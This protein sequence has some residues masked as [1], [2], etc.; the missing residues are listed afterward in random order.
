MDL[1]SKCI[2]IEDLAERLSFSNLLRVSLFLNMESPIV[3][4]TQRESSPE[5]GIY[6]FVVSKD[7]KIY[8][9]YDKS[10]LT[11]YF[12]KYHSKD[13]RLIFIPKKGVFYIFSSSVYMNRRHIGSLYVVY[14]VA[15]DKRFWKVLKDIP[16]SVSVLWCDFNSS[17]VWDIKNKKGLK[18]KFLLKKDFKLS[19]KN[20]FYAQNLL[21]PLNNKDF[22]YIFVLSSTNNFVQKIRQFTKLIFLSFIFVFMLSFFVAYLLSKR[23]T[24]PVNYLRKRCLFLSKN[25]DSGILEVQR[26]KHLEFK[27]LAEAFNKVLVSFLDAQKKLQDWAKKEISKSER[28][29]QTLVEVSPVGILALG[30]NK[31]PILWNDSFLDILNFSSQD[32]KDQDFFSFFVS[33][34]VPKIKSLFEKNGYK[35]TESV[36]ARVF[37]KDGDTKWVEVYVN[38]IRDEKAGFLVIM[39]DIDERK[40]I[41]E[42]KQV[43]INIVEQVPEA[44]ILTHTDGSIRYANKAFEDLFGCCLKEIKG[45]KIEFLWKD[46]ELFRRIFHFVSKGNSWSGRGEN[47]KKN[48]DFINVYIIVAP[49]KDPLGRIKNYLFVFQD[50]TKEVMLEKEVSKIQKLQAIGTLASGIAHDFNNILTTI[51]GHIQMATLSLSPKDK[52]YSYLEKCLEGCVRA[53]DLISQLLSFS[54]P[55]EEKKEP[56]FLTPIIKEA[57]KF[58]NASLPSNIKINLDIK[59]PSL[60]IVGNVTQVYQILANLITNAAYAMKEKGGN[61]DIILDKVVLDF[62]SWMVEKKMLLPGEYVLL[63]VKDTGVG[64]SPEVLERAFEPF[65]T[66]K[67]KGEGTGMG[68]AVVFGIVKSYN[69]HIYIESKENQGTSVFIYLPLYKKEAKV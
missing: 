31:E 1:A 20:L 35:K 13:P 38:R 30:F 64:M 33:E 69:G 49:L 52:V 12:G 42:E 11:F 2:E 58:F 18:E 61:I 28:R 68:L 17:L 10:F 36:E 26:L 39:V 40:K 22:P 41:E 43:L 32:L 45:N 19:F 5:N 44:I 9:Y 27:E 60:M 56:M 34:D 51:M 4:F 50:I 57:V 37:T 29:Y 59:D 8:S 7:K 66:T 48:G 24:S 14:D 6:V 25:P 62:D 47:I 54:R 15:K 46:R 63:V 65:F 55:G 16:E 23:I 67:P 53:K 3:E 21:C